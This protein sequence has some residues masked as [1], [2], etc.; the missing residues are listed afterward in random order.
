[1]PLVAQNA[2]REDMFTPLSGYNPHR[3]MCGGF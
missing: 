3:L 1:M 2:V